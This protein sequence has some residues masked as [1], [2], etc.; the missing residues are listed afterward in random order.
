MIDLHC[1]ILP[2]IDDGAV[3]LAVSLQMARAFVADGVS[4]VACTPHILPGLY[5]NSGPQ[6][7]QATA[8]LQ[9]VLDKE[10]ISLKLVSGAD[11]HMIA[12]FVPQLRSGN[13][14]SLADSR[15]VLVE[16]PHHVV[17]PRIEDLFFSLLVD[18]YV[19]I[20]THP[21]R[22]TWIE[23]QYGTLQQLVRAGV[24]MQL[25][26]GSL[27][28]AFGR[29]ARY[30]AERMLEE[31]CAHI[32]ATDAH[33]V[34]RRPPNLK[35]GR[36]LAARRVGEAEAERLVVTRPKGVLLNEPPAN[37]PPPAAH[38]LAGMT[39]AKAD[40]LKDAGYVAENGRCDR[41]SADRGP[42]RWLRGLL[43]WQQR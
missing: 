31:G 11:N 40:V 33:D 14:L 23:G 29:N 7:R 1:H 43:K 5:H 13:L 2:G 10:G 4:V 32:L 37:L 12:E 28:G 9:Q 25:T 30:W 18:G 19:P 24:W 21:E 39:H 35:H 15:Y 16:P 38:S 6:I 27:A 3:D 26:A 34:G 41:G 17:P 42:T 22:L 36:E 8:Q 20:L